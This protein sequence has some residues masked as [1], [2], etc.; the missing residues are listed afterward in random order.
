LPDFTLLSRIAP[1]A[2][3]VTLRQTFVRYCHCGR[4]SAGAPGLRAPALA[5]AGFA[6]NGVL[7][8]DNNAAQFIAFLAAGG[9]K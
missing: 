8:R 7:P 6:R 3:L 1:R 9:L 2:G 5:T 4:P